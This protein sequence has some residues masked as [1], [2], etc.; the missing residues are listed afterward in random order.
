VAATVSNAIFWK[1][2]IQLKLHVNMR[3]LS[4]AH[5]MNP[6]HLQ[7]AQDFS[8]WL[9]R[10]GDAHDDLISANAEVTLPEGTESIAFYLCR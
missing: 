6:E 5:Q 2:V 9:L 8:D 4:Q 7:K 3:L 10:I 1:D